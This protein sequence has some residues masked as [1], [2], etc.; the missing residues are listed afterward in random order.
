MNYEVKLLNAVLESGDYVECQNENVGKVFINYQ[1]VWAFISGHY[2]DHGKIP[3]KAEIKSHFPDF[4]YLTTTEPLA[5]YIDEARKE[6]MAFLARELMVSTHEMLKSSGPKTALNYLVSNAN[7]LVK[8]ATNLKDTDLSG[9]W[10]DRLGELKKLSEEDSGGTVGIPSGI[11]V[12]DTEFGGWQPGDFIVLLGWTGCGKSFLTR[13]FAVNAWLAGYRPMIISLEMGK[14]QEANRIDTILNN[15]KGFFTHSD[16]VRPNSEVVDSYRKWG[17]DTFKEMQP[18]YLITSDGLDVAD[19]NFVQ[20]KIDQYKPD[21]VILD[22]HGLF[23]DASGAKSETEKAKNL[24]KAFKRMAVKN[25][26]P[27]V[28]VAAVTMQDGHSDRP[29][30]LEEVAWSKQLAYDADLVLAL[31]REMDSSIFQVVSRKVRRC[32]HFGF[33]LDWNLETGEWKEEWGV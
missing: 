32:T 29:P 5:Y 24:S 31:H 14:K 28:D 13:L 11:S 2:D 16:L 33:F 7:Q 8:D 1:D 10:R 21:L 6:S 4:E 26:V 12:I 30:E 17:E 19:Q 25:N 27:I 22:Y 20:A 18:F 9:E 23:D 15:G 3:A